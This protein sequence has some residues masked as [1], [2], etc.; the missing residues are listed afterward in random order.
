MKALMKLARIFASK[1]WLLSFLLLPLSYVDI[2]MAGEYAKLGMVLLFLHG[3][4][5]GFFDWLHRVVNGY[6]D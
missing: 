4:A 3:M 1:W 2:P 6:D 5:D